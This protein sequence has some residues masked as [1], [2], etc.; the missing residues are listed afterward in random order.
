LD[1]AT[2]QGRQ[3]GAAAAAATPRLHLEDLF[4]SLLGSAA[5]SCI[6]VSFSCSYYDAFSYPALLSSS[7]EGLAMNMF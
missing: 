4:V 1:P 2:A 5:N 6:C 3:G 7:A